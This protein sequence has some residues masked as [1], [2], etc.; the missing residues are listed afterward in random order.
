MA[1]QGSTGRGRNT[2]TRGETGPG[3]EAGISPDVTGSAGSDTGMNAGAETRTT[4]GGGPQTGTGNWSGLLRKAATSR[5]ET[6]KQK[7][8]DGLGGVAR[9]IRDTTDQLR[10]EGR[11]AA[12]DY[13]RQAAEQLERLSDRINQQDLDDVVAGV[14]RFARRQPA[15]FVGAAFAV[16]LLGARFFKSSS[17]R[18]RRQEFARSYESTYGEASGGDIAARGP[19][20][21]GPDVSSSIQVGGG[22]IS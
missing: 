2:R 18:N 6:Q 13:A 12:A 3:A 1:T 11:A 19:S 22:P 8:A 17:E 21:Q 10:G 14:Q 20:T 5:I 4:T 15:A 7:A 16:G 9:A